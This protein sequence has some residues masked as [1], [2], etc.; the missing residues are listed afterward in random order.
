MF[1]ERPDA[2]LFSL[3][4]GQGPFTLFTLGG[5]SAGGELWY[6]VFGRLP[7]WRCVSLDH[8]GTGVTTHE[9]GSISIDAMVDDLFAVMDAQGIDGPCVLGAESS[10]ATIALEAALRA[11]HRFAGLVL[12]DASWVR[13]P[14]AAYDGL[15]A[16]LR[17]DFEGA[18]QAFVAACLTSR[19]GPDAHRWGMQILRRSTP[20][21]AID[22]L[23]CRLAATVDTRVGDIRIPALLIH[24]DEDRITPFA[25]SRRLAREMPQAELHVLEGQGH[26]PIVTVPAK[27]A[28]LIERKFG[29]PLD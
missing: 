27:V 12:V 2:R 25:D 18:L 19:D 7:Q 24:G 1:V 11:P 21:A 5:W 4:F 14:G 15:I 8:R 23:R 26:V 16:G 10:G 9:P 28:A 3:S 17:A 20:Q 29:A 6:E 13:L 22:L